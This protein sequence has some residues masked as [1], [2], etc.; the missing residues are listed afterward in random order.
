[1]LALRTG[2]YRA[3]EEA[4]V[5]D[6]LAI[7]RGD[8][9]ADVLVIS[10][11]GGMLNAI[12]HRLASQTPAL[13]QTEFLTFFALAE[14]ILSEAPLADDHTVH[15]PALIREIIHDFLAGRGDI[16]LV[17]RDIVS[18]PGQPVSR[19]LAGALSATLKDLQDS[20]ARVV[21]VA[22]VAREGHLGEGVGAAIPALELNVLM[23]DTLRKRQLRTGADFMRRA[24]EALPGSSWLRRQKAIF[25]YGF[26]DLTGVQLDLILKLADHPHATLFFPF[27]HGNPAYAYAEKL[28]KD[29]ALTTKTKPEP[30][31]RTQVGETT[32]PTP[33]IEAFSCSGIQDEVWLAAKKILQLHTA[34]MPFHRIAVQV[35]TLEPYLNTLRQ[36]FDAHHIPFTLHAEEPVGAYPMIKVARQL[37]RQEPPDPSPYLQD[38]I[39]DLKH[40]DQATWTEHGQ[41]ALTTLDASMRLPDDASPIE[42][43]LWQGLHGAIQSLFE[44]DTLGRPVSF[45]RF[46]EVLEEKLE[47]L[48]LALDAAPN[49][50]VQILDVMSSR[51]LYFDAVFLLGLNEKLFP[52]LIRE[53]PFL[54]DAARSA[55][56]QALGA[57]LPRKMDGFQEERLLFELV[58][59]SA[60]K[61]LH[62]SC[63]RSDEE[64]KALVVSLYL[65]D[66]LQRNGLELQRLPRTWT[67]KLHAV[68][69][70]TLTPKEVSIAM[71]RDQQDID[72]LYPLL[73]WNRDL[74]HHLLKS[75]SEIEGFGPLGPHDGLIGKDHPLARMLLQEG[76][77]PHTLK[78]LAE[79]PFKV[80]GRK[81]LALQPDEA[82]ADQGELTNTGRGKLIHEILETFHRGP[83]DPW[84]ERLNAIASD[85][86]RRVE[87]DYPDLYPL[88]WQ[89]EKE[90]VL[91]MLRRFVP[92]DLAQIRA[93]GM[94]PTHFETSLSEEINGLRLQGRIDRL[95]IKTG[96][97]PAFRV[98]DYK[99]GSGGIKKGESIETAIIKGKSFQLPVYLLLAKAWLEKQL[100]GK[101]M[102]GEAAFYRLGED[103]ALAEPLRIGPEFWKELGDHFT[104]NLKFIVQN[105]E[106]GMFY[107]RPSD[108]RGYCL[109]CGFAALCRKEHKPSQIRSENS[110]I[111]K[112]HETA[113]TPKK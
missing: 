63:Q 106:L 8:P 99:T 113:F 20:G 67:E 53:D 87:R 60:E 61:R 41:W 100:K 6:V 81:V 49:A 75:Q 4:L 9:L 83:T 94:R 15:E 25:L 48:R 92:L 66:F 58:V 36:V 35:R 57:R 2:S 103:D 3:L 59:R 19:G 47:G 5:Q 16:P 12:Q 111:R 74:M 28:L 38:S 69:L 10:P 84:E 88:A 102:I 110:P 18:R 90:R 104:D 51:G 31:T 68:P 76:L 27:E 42:R 24:A 80:Y 112:Q 46:L 85:V 101:A 77:S 91:A 37:L 97:E 7:K 44:L 14:R 34:G 82:D 23:Y 70:N 72:A 105:I 22:N 109:W 73:G 40:S 17:S 29:P 1:M 26:Y 33:E 71:H 32:K 52:R 55:L 54:P 62:L 45:S 30:L 89:A 43:R 86:F 21:D 107:I 78:D 39:A 98:V 93:T 56:A 11:S 96:A 79:C 50:G 108:S 95:D 65:H 64:G 13:L